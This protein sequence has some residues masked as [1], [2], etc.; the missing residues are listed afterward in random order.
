MCEKKQC[1]HFADLVT[2]DCATVA[3]NETQ[4]RNGQNNDKV[5]V[6]L[7]WPLVPQSCTQPNDIINTGRARIAVVSGLVGR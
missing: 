2:I 7:L 4:Q 5:A 3:Q 6:L 1:L